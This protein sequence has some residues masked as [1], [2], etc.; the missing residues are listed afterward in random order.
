MSR[1]YVTAMPTAARK[2]QHRSYEDRQQDA[3]KEYLG[4]E[5]AKTAKQKHE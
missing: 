4:H 1:S 2:S 3:E 5:E